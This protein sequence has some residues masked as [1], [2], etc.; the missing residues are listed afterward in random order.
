MNFCKVEYNNSVIHNITS[1]TG[2]VELNTTNK[3][4]TSDI[5][6]TSLLTEYNGS[7]SN[8]VTNAEE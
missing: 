5:K 2:S 1:S 6:V 8:T 7:I 3:W 4:A